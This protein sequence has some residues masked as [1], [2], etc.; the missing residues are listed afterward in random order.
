[1]HKTFLSRPRSRPR[2]LSQDQDLCFCPRGA[3]RQDLGLEDYITGWHVSGTLRWRSREMIPVTRSRKV[4]KFMFSL[5]VQPVPHLLSPTEASISSILPHYNYKSP[6]T[7][8]SDMHHLTCGISSLLHS[9]KSLR[10]CFNPD[11]KHKGNGRRSVH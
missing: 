1:M 10:R 5:H 2:L 7:P 11:L 8:L 9:I 4:S 3:S 6:T